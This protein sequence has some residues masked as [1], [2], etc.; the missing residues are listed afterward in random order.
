MEDMGGRQV[1]PFKG[2]RMVSIEVDPICAFVARHFL[3]LANLLCNMEVWTGTIKD[4]ATRIQET[5]GERTLAFAFLD[6]KGSR[7]HIDFLK[8]E[9][10]DLLAPKSRL[11]ADNTVSPGAPILLWNLKSH[12]GFVH[13]PWALEEY[14][15]EAIEDWMAVFDF[16]VPIWG[17]R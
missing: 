7:F 6:Y 11:V 12:P 15:E 5:W 2:P 4:I 16:E 14:L 9:Q 3:D 17:P 1:S 13:T 10:M 8:W